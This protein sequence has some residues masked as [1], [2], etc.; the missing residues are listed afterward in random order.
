ML[1]SKLTSEDPEFASKISKLSSG[2]EKSRYDIAE[3]MYGILS[4]SGTLNDSVNML[5][6][7]STSLT[8]SGR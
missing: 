7:L 8:F 3:E 6:S 1:L 2:G 5:H 4:N